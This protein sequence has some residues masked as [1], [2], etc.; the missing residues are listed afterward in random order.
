MLANTSIRR[1][2]IDHWWLIASREMSRQPAAISSPLHP[3]LLSSLFVVW[4]H[5]QLADPPEKH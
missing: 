4:C 5:T 2:L 3:G 1:F